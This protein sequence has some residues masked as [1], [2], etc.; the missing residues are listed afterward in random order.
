MASIYKRPGSDVYQCQFYV[1]QPEGGLK[2]IRKST[3]KTNRKE[4][5]QVAVELERTGQ[6]AIKA[7]SDEGQRAKGILAEAVS[8]VERGTF[9]AAAARK[10]VARLLAVATGEEMPEFSVEGWCQEWLRRKARDSSKGTMARYKTSIESFLLHLGARKVKPLESVTMA[11]VRAWRET[12]QDGGRAGK[13]V[14]KYAK[15]VGSAFRAAIREGLI[16][17]NPCSA[18][19]AVSTEDSLDRKPF[20][21]GEVV[22]LMTAAPSTEWRGLILAAAFTGLRLGDASRLSWSS[23]DLASKTITLVPSKTKKKKREVTIPIQPDL[24]NFLESLEI[25]DDSPAAPVFPKL[26]MI[27][28]AGGSGLSKAFEKIMKKANVDRGRASRETGEDA[29]DVGAGRVIFE[30]GFH[31]LRHTFTTWLR[32]AGVAE[33][34]R[35]ALTGHSTRGSHA[36]YSHADAEVLHKAIAKLPS[37]TESK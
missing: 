1:S 37:L 31:S 9:N 35:M 18:L 3:G 25:D 33:E 20:T 28:D 21:I 34:D 17:S 10:Y 30:R 22:S 7:G 26:A 5:M 19:E 32:T 24:L 8:E 27:A 16:T 29:K 2:K 11:N 4:A 23:I 13:T 14:N 36:I 15:D 6:G 12:L